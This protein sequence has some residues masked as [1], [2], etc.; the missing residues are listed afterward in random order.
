MLIFDSIDPHG[1]IS[2]LIFQ[3]TDAF[4]CSGIKITI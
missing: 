2:M 1:V 4:Q 3:L